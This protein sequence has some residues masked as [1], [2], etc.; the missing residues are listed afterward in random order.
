MDV[1]NNSNFMSCALRSTGVWTV[2][3]SGRLYI[4][5]ARHERFEL[6]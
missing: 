2:R 1:D 4:P 6:W 5:T 3:F